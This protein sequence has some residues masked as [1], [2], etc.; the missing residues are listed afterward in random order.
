MSTIWK[1][2]AP[3]KNKHTAIPRKLLKQ[4]DVVTA[5]ELRSEGCACAVSV[6]GG[7]ERSV[8]S[9]P[10]AEKARRKAFCSSSSRLVRISVSVV[11][12]RAT[13]HQHHVYFHPARAGRSRRGR[14][15]R[16]LWRPG[17]AGQ[18]WRGDVCAGTA[19]TMC[20]P[21][22]PPNRLFTTRKMRWFASV[23]S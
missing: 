4:D 17:N 1:D 19:L 15:V 6:A 23:A 22:S 5:K 9:P 12:R 3:H 2:F 8:H 16:P 7:F 14:A 13:H 20:G 21:S 18:S 11:C 10:R